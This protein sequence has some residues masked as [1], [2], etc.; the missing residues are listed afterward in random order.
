M[1]V[2]IKQAY[3]QRIAEL[4]AQPPQRGTTIAALCQQVSDLSKHA[5]DLVAERARL[6]SQSLHIAKAPLHAQ[7]IWD[8]CYEDIFIRPV[9]ELGLDCALNGG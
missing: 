6:V 9:S 1:D 4:T 5:A 8:E 3:Q 7:E 2:R